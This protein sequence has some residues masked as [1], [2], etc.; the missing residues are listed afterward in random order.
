MKLMTGIVALL[1]I[2]TLAFASTHTEGTEETTTQTIAPKHDDSED[3]K[4]T[5]ISSCPDCGEDKER[6]QTIASIEEEEANRSSNDEPK[7]E[8]KKAVI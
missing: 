4:N 5:V 8:G 7:D 6:S 3:D 1:T 2:S